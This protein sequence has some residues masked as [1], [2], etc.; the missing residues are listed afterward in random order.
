MSDNKKRTKMMSCSATPT[1][2]MNRQWNY[3]DPGFVKTFKKQEFGQIWLGLCCDNPKSEAVIRSYFCDY[4]EGTQTTRPVLREQEYEV[5]QTITTTRTVITRWKNL[6][7]EADNTILR[8][9]RRKDP[10]N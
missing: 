7:A 10:D 6:V 9:K 4:V 1:T 2:T 8:E 3:D 5:V